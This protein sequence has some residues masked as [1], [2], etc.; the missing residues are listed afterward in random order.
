MPITLTI[1]N[2]SQEEIIEILAK[3]A[4]NKWKKDFK[5]RVLNQLNALNKDMSGIEVLREFEKIFRENL[6]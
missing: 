3:D 5:Q 4:L 1:E 6:G 2:L